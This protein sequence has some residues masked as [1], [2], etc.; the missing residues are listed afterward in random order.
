M[1]RHLFLLAWNQRRANALVLFEVLTCFLVLCGLLTGVA[2]LVTTWN[3]PLGFTYHDVHHV[4]VELRTEGSELS[5]GDDAAPRLARLLAETAAFS[6]V[7]AAALTSNTPWSGSQRSNT[8]WVAGRRISVLY[9]PVTPALREVLQLELVSGRWIEAG[10]SAPGTRPAILTESLARGFYGTEDPIGKIVPDFDDNGRRSEAASGREFKVVGVVRDYRRGGEFSTEGWAMFVPA[11]LDS[12]VFG[13]PDELLVRLRPGTPPETEERILRALQALEP[14]W[15]F[16]IDPLARLRER[17]L[18]QFLIPIVTLGL[19][20]GFL[21]FMVGLGLLGVLWQGV[22]RRTAEFGVRRALGA[23]RRDILTQILGEIAA[24]AS[25][26]V[27]VGTIVFLQLPLLGVLP[28]LAP[29]TY[30]AGLCGALAMI[31][32]LVLLC[33][34]YPGWLATRVEPALALKHD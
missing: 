1:I 11:R 25:L 29:G 20:A 15:S 12:A 30:L 10:D 6:E 13:T 26:A 9:T 2:F 18:R 17:E 28:F 5:G 22:V 7:E 23:T 8:A 3:R 21:V 31:Y 14:E 32:A 16:T 33:G 4:G 19:I 27:A 24:L 34:L